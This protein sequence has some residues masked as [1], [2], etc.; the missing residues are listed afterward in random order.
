MR[1]R[2][3]NG[4]EEIDVPEFHNLLATKIDGA[5]TRARLNFE[6]HDVPA[7]GLKRAIWKDKKS[8]FVTLEMNEIEEG[9][10]GEDEFFLLKFETF[11]PNEE[12]PHESE[13]AIHNY[14]QIQRNI[15][16]R[17]MRPILKFFAR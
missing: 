7:P 6:R 1:I 13:A 3:G 5:L 15:M 14:S 8:W 11:Y 16:D 12:A 4:F 2:R 10:T 9:K 17:L